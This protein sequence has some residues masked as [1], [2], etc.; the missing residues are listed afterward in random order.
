[1]R[2]VLIALPEGRQRER[3]RILK[4]LQT[5][6]VEVKVLPDVDDI[7]SGRVRV[8]DLR[9]LEVNDLLG[10][11]KVPANTDLL[12]RKTRDKSI[13][14]T[15]AGGRWIE[16]VRQLIKQGPR[17]IVLFDISGGALRDRQSARDHRGLTRRR[18]A[19]DR[20]RA[21]LGADVAQMRETVRRHEIE[22][23]YH[24]AAYKRADRRAEPHRPA[25]N[26]QRRRPRRLRQS[27]GVGSWCSS[28]R[29]R[30]CAPPT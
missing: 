18:G 9:S 11:D 4:E 3:R 17:R 14:V 12:A 13:M 6:P 10:R 28:P 21:R 8:T 24:A 7:T 27:G 15:G 25:G 22:V 5:H 19:P 16:L 26:L 30:P 1:V 2:E 20:R 29:I 23:I